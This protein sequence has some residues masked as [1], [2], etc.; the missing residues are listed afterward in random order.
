MDLRGKALLGVD[1]GTH[2]IKIVEVRRSYGGAATLTQCGIE[3]IGRRYRGRI[4][5]ESLCDIQHTLP[6]KS[7]AD[8]EEE[9]QLLLASWATPDGGFILI[10]YGDG[11]AIGVS[12]ERKRVMLDAFLR[13]DP[14]RK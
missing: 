6:F 13:A 10:D 4:C 7:H 5:F 2:G 8:I 14:W 11:E 12:L 9:A 3:E 1:I